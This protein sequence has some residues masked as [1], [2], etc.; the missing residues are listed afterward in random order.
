MRA[1]VQVKKVGPRERW[2][3]LLSLRIPDPE[4]R[5]GLS[6]A[7]DVGW[8]ETERGLRVAFL[9]DGE[10]LILPREVM[11]ALNKADSL[12]AIRDRAFDEIKP[13]KR[14]RNIAKLAVVARKS[15]D[16]KLRA[17][18]Y[19]DHHLWQWE[20]SQRTKSLARRREVYRVF[21]ARLAEKYAVLIREDIDLSKLARKQPEESEKR[22]SA[23]S[24]NRFLASLSEL[25]SVLDNAFVSRGG[26]VIKVD[27][28][29]TSRQCSTCGYDMGPNSGLVLQCTNCLAV[30]D[31]DANASENIK[32]RGLLAM[33]ENPCEVKNV[34]ASAWAK[35]R[36]K[37][38]QKP[39]A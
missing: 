16:P 35:R 32:Q 37:K 27:P 34:Q 39:A 15:D 28:A 31:R 38:G 36:S 14:M 7:I 19:Q 12:R 22:D 25:F 21:A 5:D 17:W 18:R 24:G 8:R 4:P 23:S 6:V 33:S 9:S 20:T 10:E 13:D 26:R 3:L 1:T 29:G 11:S 30:H 2:A